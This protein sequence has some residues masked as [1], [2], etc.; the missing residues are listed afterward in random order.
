MP[1]TPPEAASPN[2]QS[3]ATPA[4]SL[5]AVLPHTAA[6]PDAP[7]VN[8]KVHLHGLTAKPSLNGTYGTALSFD[9][10]TGRYAVRL[11]AGGARIALKPANLRKATDA[12]RAGAGGGEAG[13]KAAPPRKPLPSE[14]QAKALFTELWREREAKRESTTGCGTTPQV[15]KASVVDVTDA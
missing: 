15:E 14:A 1:P 6:A 2:D 10:L 9:Q 11:D 3:A 8:E 12:T 7:L 4:P 13:A 5:P